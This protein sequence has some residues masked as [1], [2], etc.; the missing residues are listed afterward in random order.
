MRELAH[1]LGSRFQ[2]AKANQ[3]T[4]L[5]VANPLTERSPH[6]FTRLFNRGNLP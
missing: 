6:S 1:V 5:V 3:L 2:Q 4:T